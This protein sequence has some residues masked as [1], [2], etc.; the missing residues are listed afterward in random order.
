M[1]L[2]KLSV[3]K[4]VW[5]ERILGP[6]KFE[7][8]RNFGSTKIGPQKIWVQ[9]NVSQKQFWVQKIV[10]HKKLLVKKI[11]GPI[12]SGQNRVSAIYR[13]SHNIVPTFV[14]LISQPPK[15]LEVPSWTFFDSPFNVDFKTIQFVIIW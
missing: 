5:S 7:S 15:H 6:K 11:C 13:L 2:K 10:V 1:G 14:L 12:F 4:N 3:K 8:E 9:K